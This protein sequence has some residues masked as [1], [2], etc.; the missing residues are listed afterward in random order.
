MDDKERRRL[1][2]VLAQHEL[3]LRI[4]VQQRAHTV[5]AR[6]EQTIERIKAK[7]GLR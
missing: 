4:A 2:K 3:T 7:L 1:T 6:E 5:A